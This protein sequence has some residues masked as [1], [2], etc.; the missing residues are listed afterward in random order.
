MASSHADNAKSAALRHYPE[1]GAGG[2]SHVDGTIEFYSRVNALIDRSSVVLDLG[3]GR[4]KF[5]TDPVAYR[6]ELRSL[7]GRVQR[8][9]GIDVDASVL[10]NVTLDEAHV[11]DASS[12]FPLEDRSVDIIISDFTFEHITN[13]DLVAAEVERVLRPGGWLCARTPNKWGYIGV[14]ARAVPNRLHVRSLRVLQP[15]KAPEDTFDVAYRLNTARSLRLHFPQDRFD[16]F[17]YAMNNEPA[18]FA[19]SGLAWAAA[20]TAFRLLPRRAGAV[21]YV[22]LRKLADPFNSANGQ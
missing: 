12:P 13:P 10:Q 1:I 22:F 9:I 20:L 2:F 19:D 14:G 18:Y 5:V 4:G 21:L 17:T 6:R 7:K 3:A 16:H 8:L 11:I 15:E